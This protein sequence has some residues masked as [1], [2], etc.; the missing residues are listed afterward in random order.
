MNPSGLLPDKDK[1]S[2]L[3]PQNKCVRGC[4]ISSDSPAVKEFRKNLWRI[5]TRD[6]RKDRHSECWITHRHHNP[7]TS[8]GLLAFFDFSGSTRLFFLPR[9][10]TA[11]FAAGRDN[12]DTFYLFVDS[13]GLEYET[14][15]WQRLTKAEAQRIA[16]QA[17]R[18]S[19][20]LAAQHVPG[21]AASATPEMTRRLQDIIGFP[22]S[23]V[24]PSETELVAHNK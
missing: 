5:A 15:V 4:R 13:E 2:L 3:A 20:W 24:K 14:N 6:H 22:S 11:I 16:K 23:K 1:V 21:A 17:H 12:I 8:L 18:D 7:S 10:G 19:H 9:N